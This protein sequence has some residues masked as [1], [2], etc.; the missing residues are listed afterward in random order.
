MLL[1]QNWAQKPSVLVQVLT[2]RGRGGKISFFRAVKNGREKTPKP[3]RLRGFPVRYLFWS[4]NVVAEAGLE[5]TASGLWARRATNCST[6]R[7]EIKGIL[8]PVTGLEPVQYCYRGILSPLCL[9]IPP[10]RQISATDNIP[11]LRRDVNT[12]L[13]KTSPSAFCS[14]DLSALLCYTIL[15]SVS[16]THLTL[17]TICSV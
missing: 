8:V 13:Q 15:V 3:L 5:P 10:H 14:F 2:A 9:P 6:P 1:T 16:Y 4:H 11:Y 12:C 7:Y 17:P